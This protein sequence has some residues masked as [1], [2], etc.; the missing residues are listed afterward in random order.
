MKLTELAKKL[1]ISTESLK[2][3]IQDFELDLDEVLCPNFDVKPEFEKFALENTD[4][5]QQ[6]ASD[7]EKNKSV[8]EIADKINQPKEKV[9][10]IIKKN[11]TI[12]D[13]GM[14][15]S[16]VSSFGVDYKLGG[17]YNFVYD[18]FGN[19]TVLAERDFIGYRDLF[20][21]ISDVLESFINKDEAK[22]W[23]IEKPA[24]IILYGVPGSGK[25]F[26]ANKI[27]EIIG[28]QLKEVKKYYLGNSYPNGNRSSFN[29]FLISMMKEKKVILFLEN[30]DEIT[31]EKSAEYT[32]TKENNETS[33]IILHY[34]NKFVEEDLLMVGSANT[35]SGIDEEILAP[36]RF[37]V[38]IPVFPP[39]A[40]ERAEVILYSLTRNLEK[41]STLY[42]ILE[43]NDAHRLPFWNPIAQKMKTFSNTMVIDFT[44]S[45]KKRI[46][47]IYYKSR[48]EN[49]KIDA[50]ILESALRDASA[51]LTEEYLNQVQQFIYDVSTHNTDDFPVRLEN[52]KNELETY[53]VVEEPIR[54]IGFHHNEE[55]KSS[56]EHNL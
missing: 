50:A 6:Y 10:E 19:K 52:L 20:F 56:D 39:N 16:S 43:K 24:G 11:P 37:D 49:L 18:Y 42:K 31:Q 1:N 22:N 14:Y 47:K 2:C 26:W 38:L 30:F 4:F 7:L 55:E 35:L 25:I 12:L 45:L 51:K 41:N 9:E 54:T 8:E 23:G 34:I 13:N 32:N 27:S 36:G 3:F 46:R 29:N 15:K 21:Y 40:K 33:E 48:N 5:L 53:K 44:Q 28:Y 17:N